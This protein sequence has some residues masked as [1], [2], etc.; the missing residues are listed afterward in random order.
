M[1]SVFSFKRIREEL[2]SVLVSP[3]PDSDSDLDHP[4]SPT[5]PKERDAKGLRWHQAEDYDPFF[6]CFVCKNVVDRADTRP[7]MIIRSYGGA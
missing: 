4:V 3:N 2:P 5:C 6:S 1:D 7:F